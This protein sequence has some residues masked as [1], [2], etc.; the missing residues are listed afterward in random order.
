MTPSG[1]FLSQDNVFI[2]ES[3]TLHIFGARADYVQPLPGNGKL[4][5]GLKASYVKTF[6]NSTYY[7]QAGGQN[8]V[9]SAMSDYNINSENINA[10]YINVNSQYGKLT[11][12]AGL[13]AE[14]TVMKGQQLFTNASVDQNYFELFPTLFLSYKLNDQNTFNFQFG[15]RVD[16]P[17]YHELVPFR[18]PLSANNLFSGKSE[19]ETRSELAFGTYLVMAE[20]LFYYRSL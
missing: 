16:R 8:V 13:R 4:E 15:R 10:A 6:N 18:R 9:D 17:D 11:V 5:T 12:Q 2:D 7:N 20:Y 19:F 1:S 14:Q 3:R